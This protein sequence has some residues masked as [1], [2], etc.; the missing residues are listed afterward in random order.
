MPDQQQIAI[1]LEDIANLRR[2]HTQQ[3]KH[4]LDARA[5]NDGPAAGRVLNELVS[6]HLGCRDLFDVVEYLLSTW[7]P[8]SD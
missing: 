2:M 7:A 6:A 1:S 5:A 8:P 3:F 4:L